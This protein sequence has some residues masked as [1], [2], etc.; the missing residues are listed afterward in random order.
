MTSATT[1]SAAA[2][3]AS[4]HGSLPSRNTPGRLS[5]QTPECAQI[6]RLSWMVIC[7]PRCDATVPFRSVAKRRPLKPIR[8]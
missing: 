4:I 5:V 6:A 1:T 2:A 3:S 7:L 8:V